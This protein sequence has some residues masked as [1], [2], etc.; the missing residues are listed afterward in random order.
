MTDR[1]FWSATLTRIVQPVLEAAAAGTLAERMPCETLP[2]H[3]SGADRRRFNSLEAV[4]RTLAGLAP[5]LETG[6]RPALAALAQRALANAPAILNF[7]SG[8]Q[9][10]VDAA[11]LAHGLLRAPRQL[12]GALEAGA[13]GRLIDALQATR[14]ITPAYNNW[15]LFSALIEAFLFQATGTCDEMRIDYAVRQHEH[16]Y[17]GDGAYGDGPDFHWDYYNSFVIQP[18]L[19]DVLA[20]VQRFDDAWRTRVRQR[21]QRYG[22]ILERLISPAG[23]FPPV[24]RSLAY[25]TGA[26]QLL[27]QLALQNQLPAELPAGQVRAALTAVIRACFTP[28]ETFDENGWLRIGLAGHQPHLAEVYIATGSLYLCTTGFLP[29]GLPVTHDFWTAPAQPW[30]GQKI[31]GGADAPADHA[32]KG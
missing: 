13:Q 25:R 11:F 6:E 16:W 7:T 12:W 8:G 18:M 19:L 4:G 30:T 29:L 17:K 1:Q 21:A 26:F 27:A 28:T 31:W 5:W 3:P 32:L 10:L 15:L 24:G 22:V 2:G 20:A 9:P 14:R 23:T